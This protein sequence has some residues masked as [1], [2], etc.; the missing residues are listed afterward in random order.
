MFAVF[1]YLGD[2]TFYRQSKLSA[3]ISR[4]AGLTFGIYL[5]HILIMHIVGDGH[6]GFSLNIDTFAPWFSVPL[7]ATVVF[8]LSA[9]A[10]WLLKKIPFAHWILP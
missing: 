2:T 10:V 6:L 1:K 5:V 4:F 3:G 7:T 9:L 8:L